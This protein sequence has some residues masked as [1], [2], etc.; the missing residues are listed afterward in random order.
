MTRKQFDECIQSPALNPEGFKS[1]ESLKA[2]KYA[3]Y[4]ESNP[5][6]RND[7]G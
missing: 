6:R 4:P 3:A 1:L 2:K 7:H 5:F